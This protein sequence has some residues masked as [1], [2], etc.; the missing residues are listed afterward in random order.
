MHK[1]YQF[2]ESVATIHILYV[3]IRK[4]SPIRFGIRLPRL[5]VDDNAECGA[6]R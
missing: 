2:A 6:R 1:L 5:C 4:E 3:Y